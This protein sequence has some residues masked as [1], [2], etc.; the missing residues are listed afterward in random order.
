MATLVGNTYARDVSVVV[1]PTIGPVTP[2][3][4]VTR[5]YTYQVPTGNVAE[6][7]DEPDASEPV[8]ACMRLEG[9]VRP[10]VA[11]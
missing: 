7:V 6:T 9:F 4:D 5:T 11:P 8:P 2:D 3:G 10:A 1:A